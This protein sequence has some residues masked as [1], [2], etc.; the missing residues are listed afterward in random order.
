MVLGA[1]SSSENWCGFDLDR[2]WQE[3]NFL[4]CRNLYICSFFTDDFKKSSSRTKIQRPF[5][6]KT[7]DSSLILSWLLVRVRRHWCSERK[8]IWAQPDIFCLESMVFWQGFNAFTCILYLCCRL[9]EQ[10][11]Y[12]MYMY[13]WECNK[14][15]KISV[16]IYSARL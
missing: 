13:Q 10:L 8:R 3:G 11:N 7:E 1:Y 9:I 12:K 2:Q 6:L 15:E 16:I 5:S 14:D 4:V